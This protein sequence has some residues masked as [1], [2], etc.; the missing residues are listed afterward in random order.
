[1]NKNNPISIQTTVNSSL[2]M[3]WDCW[4]KPEHITKW[5]FASDDWEAPHAENSLKIGGRFKTVMAAKNKSAQFDFTGVYTRVD[6]NKAIEY[7]IDDNRQ[8]KIKFI[9]TENGVQILQDFE[10]EKINPIEKQRAGW[11]AILN[12]F[13]KYVEKRS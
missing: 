3:V 1:M 7:T 5:A 12:N 8:V 13:K 2:K 9:L 4:T 10:P 6:V 11:Q